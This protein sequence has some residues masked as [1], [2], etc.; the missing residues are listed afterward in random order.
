MASALRPSADPL[1]FD[2]ALRMLLALSVI[3]FGQLMSPC[4]ALYSEGNLL[5]VKM[6]M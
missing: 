5:V 4:P 3:H 2:V 1:A 6:V